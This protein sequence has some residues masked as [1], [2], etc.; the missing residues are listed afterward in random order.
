LLPNLEVF[1]DPVSHD[2]KIKPGDLLAL[3]RL[4]RARFYVPPNDKAEEALLAAGF[5]R[6]S[7]KDEAPIL[8]RTTKPSATEK[9]PSAKRSTSRLAK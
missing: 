5:R 9:K 3:P 2:I 6:T 4:K 1:D 7:R 8:E